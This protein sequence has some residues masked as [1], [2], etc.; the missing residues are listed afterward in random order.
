M[1]GVKALG[2]PARVVSISPIVYPEGRAEEIAR[3][4]RRA[5]DVLVWTSDSTLPTL[6]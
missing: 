1:C 2:L 3:I 5:P 6:S 4:A